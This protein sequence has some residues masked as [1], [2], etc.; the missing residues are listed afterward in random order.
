MSTI[1]T[2]KPWVLV[3]SQVEDNYLV[4]V[5]CTSCK[6]D[7]KLTLP[8]KSFDDWNTKNGFVQDVFSEMSADVRE[9]FISG[10]CGSCWDKMF[11][12][13]PENE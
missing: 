12:G 9:M 3:E 4:S 13:F 2:K 11:G 5:T 8:V 7:T 1:Q 10:T 6:E